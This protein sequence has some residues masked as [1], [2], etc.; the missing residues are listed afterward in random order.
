MKLPVTLLIVAACGGVQ[1]D[2]PAGDAGDDTSPDA[3]V[4]GDHIAPT[5]AA[6][7]PADGTAGVTADAT[8]TIAFSEPMDRASVEGAWTSADLPASA[9]DFA[10]NA[11]SDTLVVMPHDPLVLAKGA[12]VDPSVVAPR[13]YQF[14]VGI[15]A[16]DTAGNHLAAAFAAGFTTQREMTVALLPISAL[17]RSMRGDG[18]VFGETAVTL[19]SG[20]TVSNLQ[21]KTFVSFTLPVLPAGAS[22]A[23]ATLTASQNSTLG[24]PYGLGDLVAQHVNTAVIDAAAFGAAPLSSVGVLSRSATI[25]VKA[26][27]VKTEVVDDLANHAARGERS[28]F[29]LE[30]E[31][32]TDADGVDDEARF[33]RSGMMLGLV[34]LVD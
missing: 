22:V 24:N 23:S 5:I 7:A 27:D 10:W 11:A 3:D 25:G 18:V 13:A 9:V 28:Q 29:R 31:T 4:G 14:G 19:T 34:Y 33:S 17:T 12:G 16:A 30:F 26:L 20:D 32:Q 1:T 21:T 8:I 15:G 2:P 6:T